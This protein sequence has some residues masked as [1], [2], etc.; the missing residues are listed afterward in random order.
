[1]HMNVVM[2]VGG[3]LL[4]QFLAASAQTCIIVLELVYTCAATVYVC[5]GIYYG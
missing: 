1:M 2:F 3:T 4:S 5:Y